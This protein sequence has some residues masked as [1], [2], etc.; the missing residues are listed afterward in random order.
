M[1]S[2]RFGNWHRSPTNCGGRNIGGNA[3]TSLKSLC[4]DPAIANRFVTYLARKTLE[5]VEQGHGQA[6]H[7]PRKRRSLI[8]G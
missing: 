8:A 4:Q 1:S 7:L 6:K 2:A 3:P 5:R